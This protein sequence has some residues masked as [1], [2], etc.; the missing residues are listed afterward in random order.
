MAYRWLPVVFVLVVSSQASAQTS[1][2]THDNETPAGTLRNG[3]LELKLYAGSGTWYPEN[4]T[5]AGEVVQAFGIEGQGLAVPGP[6]LRVPRGT[7]IDVAIRNT[8]P[9]AMEVHGFQSRPSTSDEAIVIDPGATRRV[10]FNA[11]SAGTYHYWATTTHATL[12]TRYGIDSQLSGAFIVDE[13]AAP[14]DHI[15]VLTAWSA[16][17][18]VG[19]PN[20]KDP[21]YIYTM[22]GKSFPH[23]SKLRYQ[24]GDRVRWRVINL[25]ETTHPMHLHGFYFDVTSDGNGLTDTVLTRDKHRRV[26]TEQLGVGETARI[27][28]SPDREGNWLF[29][30]HIVAHMSPDVGLVRYPRGTHQ[31]VEGDLGMRGLVVALSVDGVSSHRET[32]TAPARAMTLSMTPVNKRFGTEDGYGLSLDGAAAT[33]PGPLLVLKRGQPVAITL[34]NSLAEPTSIHWHGMELDSYFD[35]VPGFSGKGGSVTPMIEPGGEFIARFTPPRAGTFMYH[36][37][38]HDERVLAKGLYGP[39]IV[40]DPNETY[41]PSVDHVL[42]LGLNGAEKGGTGGSDQVLLNGR[43]TGPTSMKRGVPNRLRIINITANNDALTMFVINNLEV[44]R[45]TLAAKDGAEREGSQR[46]TMPARQ[47]VGVG[48]IY[49]FLYTPGD[50]SQWIEVRRG[51]GAFLIQSR[52]Q[53]R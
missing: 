34:K 30:C 28:W 27:E 8:L 16:E 53:P 23:T 5:G 40:V 31:H 9:V 48:E 45:W 49:D 21:R 24:V 46:E 41:D 37:H 3:R 22:N 6:L 35:G 18:L 12:L 10:T 36:T 1:I 33:T 42:M 20:P 4:S 44:A 50:G 25:T 26:V 47:T 39:I 13:P 52:I 15:F 2:L 38:S 17:P 11:G 51:S 14:R 19:N 32:V 7:E 43:L 29:H